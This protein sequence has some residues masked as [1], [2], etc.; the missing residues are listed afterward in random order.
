MSGELFTPEQKSA[1]NGDRRVVAGDL[2]FVAEYAAK[3]IS[4]VRE[5][6]QTLRESVRELQETQKKLVAL[7]ELLARQS[8]G[9][10]ETAVNAAI[11]RFVYTHENEHMKTVLHLAQ[12]MRAFQDSMVMEFKGP[13]R[14]DEQYDRGSVVQK[15]GC[16]FVA[17]VDSKGEIP[18]KGG[19]WRS[20]CVGKEEKE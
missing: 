17:L 1:I 20:I 2:L 19:A 5:E 15:N 9:M 12:T 18:G 8:G 16:T 14:S 7:I 13:F 6:V 3:S 11:K 4:S 10:D